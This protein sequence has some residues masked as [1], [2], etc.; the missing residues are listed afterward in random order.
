MMY[1]VNYQ[2]I[3]ENPFV[4]NVLCCRRQVARLVIWR[5]FKIP[6]DDLGTLR[7][8]F[9]ASRHLKLLKLKENE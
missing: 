6:I 1:F 8:I 5:F 4:H 3:S 2:I 9:F 7:S